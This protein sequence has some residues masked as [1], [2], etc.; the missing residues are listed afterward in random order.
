MEKR[1]TK[2]DYFKVALH[3]LGTAEFFRN[4]DK[5]LAS[6]YYNCPGGLD[7]E[8][9]EQAFGFGLPYEP[10]DETDSSEILALMTAQLA[11][12]KAGL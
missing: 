7:L 1:Y 4:L 11:C 5:D 6:V 9:W 2:D 8:L 10:G 3:E 12:E